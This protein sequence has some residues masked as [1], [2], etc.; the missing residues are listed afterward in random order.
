MNMKSKNVHEDECFVAA[1]LA[2]V[3]GTHLCLL[4]TLDAECS[5]KN[6]GRKRKRS[7]SKRSG[8]AQ[9]EAWLAVLIHRRLVYHGGIAG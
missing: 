9:R 3:D 1:S 7:A 4:P 8:N 6:D 2:I 5:S